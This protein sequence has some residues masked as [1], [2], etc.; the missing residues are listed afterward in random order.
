[1]AQ[2]GLMKRLAEIGKGQL[3]WFTILKVDID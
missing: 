2:I 3:D 1:M